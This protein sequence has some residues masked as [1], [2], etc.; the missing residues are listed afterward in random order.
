M[1]EEPPLTISLPPGD[2][3]ILQAALYEM[4]MKIAL[5]VANRL[6]IALDEAQ[7]PA[8]PALPFPKR[9]PKSEGGE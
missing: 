4:P 3:Q 1:P 9:G 6:K 8:A 5:P 7:R 2:W